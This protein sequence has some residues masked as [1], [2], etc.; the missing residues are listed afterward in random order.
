M[1]LKFCLL[2]QAKNWLD[3]LPVGALMEFKPPLYWIAFFLCLA[4]RRRHK[5]AVPF[6]YLNTHPRLYREA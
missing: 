6:V 4:A 2:R 1:L 3:L 5:R